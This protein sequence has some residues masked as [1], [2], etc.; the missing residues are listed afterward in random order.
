MNTI[1]PI[2][3][4]GISAMYMA[5]HR[6]YSKLP[7]S[8]ANVCG[9]SNDMNSTQSTMFVTTQANAPVLFALFQYM[10]SI[11]GIP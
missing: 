10:P 3:N 9:S 8:T 5:S 6:A 1:K 4:A 7:S 11:N 2:I